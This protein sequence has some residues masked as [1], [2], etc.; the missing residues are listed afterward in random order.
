M[1][2]WFKSK[3]SFEMHSFNIQNGQS[4]K[5]KRASYYNDYHFALTISQ[6]TSDSMPTARCIVSLTHNTNQKQ[7]AIPP[8]STIS[9]HSSFIQTSNG[10]R[11]FHL[12]ASPSSLKS[13]MIKILSNRLFEI[14]EH[15]CHIS[16]FID[17]YNIVR[18]IVRH[19]FISIPPRRTLS[20]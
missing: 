12:Y 14:A 6:V 16:S 17:Y 18:A 4:L 5:K 11:I 9:S 1:N 2:Q 3:L 15:F 20:I 19:Q 13:P 7:S 8:Q 10:I